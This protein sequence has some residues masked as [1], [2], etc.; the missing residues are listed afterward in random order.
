MKKKTITICAIVMVVFVFGVWLLLKPK[1]IANIDKAYA[2]ATSNSSAVTFQADK[3]DR[4]KFSFRSEINAGNLEIIVYSSDGRV[5][6]VLDHAK[7]LET[8][9]TFDNS[10]TYSLKAEYTDFVGSFK[11][12]IYPAN[13]K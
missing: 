8:Y 6:Y 10:D 5:V 12:A 13:V 11:I 3:G 7:E 4:V 2:S 1:A 9:Y